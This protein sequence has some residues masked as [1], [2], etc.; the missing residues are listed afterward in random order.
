MIIAFDT[1]ALSTRFRNQ[2]TYVYAKH[3]LLEL[4]ELIDSTADLSL[5]V[6]V[7]GR[8]ANDAHILCPGTS[9]ELADTCA[10][11]FNRF[12]RL[13]GA[14]VAAALTG[15]HVIFSPTPVVPVKLVPA[16]TTIHDATPMRFPTLSPFKNAFARTLLWA[17][18]RYSMR[19]I[20]DSQWSKQDLIDTFELSPDKIDVVY[21]GYDSSLFNSRPFSTPE[22]NA[23]LRR[24]G[25]LKPYVFHHG[26]VQPRK[27]LQRLIQ[28]YR[29]LLS[30]VPSL[31]LELVMAGPLGWNYEPVLQAAEQA[32]YRGKV[33]F[34]GRLSD[35]EIAMM[36]KGASLCVIPSLYE[37]FCLPLVEAMACGVPTVASSAS[38]LA[39]VSAGSLR[40]FDPCSIEDMAGVMQ[41]VLEDQSLQR[42]LIENGLKR[43]ADFSWK[44]CAQQTLCALLQ[45]SQGA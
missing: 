44:R 9:V 2:G 29:L 32:G 37:G 33:R 12:W 42:Q 45:A 11:R 41:T 20:T 3:L 26:V 34:V 38:C 13:G 10:L 40:Y 6:F 14:T 4:R 15:A 16:V 23:L 22:H 17:S 5:R 35:D 43:A 18:A 27:N 28:A 7:C 25:I 31:D 24:H 36:L 21:L 39:E 19:V 30:R 8:A 1:W